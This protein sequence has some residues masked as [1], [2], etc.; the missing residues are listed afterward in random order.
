MSYMKSDAGPTASQIQAAIE[1]F[2]KEKPV[3]F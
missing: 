1:Y 3:I 2:V